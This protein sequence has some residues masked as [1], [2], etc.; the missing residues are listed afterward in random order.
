MSYCD[1]EEEDD[2]RV[3][4]ACGV[5]LEGQDEPLDAMFLM[6]GMELSGEA[7]FDVILKKKCPEGMLTTG[8]PSIEGRWG[9]AFSKVTFCERTSIGWS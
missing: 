5:Y 6:N 2:D 8:R 1:D 3:R 4:G 9:V 7:I